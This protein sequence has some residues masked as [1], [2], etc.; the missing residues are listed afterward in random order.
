MPDGRRYIIGIA[1]ERHRYSLLGG[2]M[3]ALLAIGLGIALVAWRKT[4]SFTR[5]LDDI[6]K[7]GLELDFS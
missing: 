2:L 6:E 5:R 1:F 4:S 7:L 3:S